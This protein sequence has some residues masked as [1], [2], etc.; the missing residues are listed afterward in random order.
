MSIPSEISNSN[1]F[2]DNSRMIHIAAEVLVVSGLTSYVI[3]QNKK[4]NKTISELTV[5]LEEK[6]EMYSK[7]EAAVGQLNSVLGQMTQKLQQHDNGLNILSE[8]INMLSEESGSNSSSGPNPPSGPSGKDLSEMFKKGKSANK[9][10]IKGKGVPAETVKKH[11]KPV[12]K[13]TPQVSRVSKIQFKKPIVEDDSDDDKVVG[14]SKI[15]D[16]L[17]DSDLDDEISQELAELEE[18]D[19]EDFSLKKER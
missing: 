2:L 15:S 16:D 12:L 5:K 14:K 11:V 7:L 1:I 13:E 18:L 9:S 4:L 10:V 6:D 17:S 3:Y 19:G 8:R